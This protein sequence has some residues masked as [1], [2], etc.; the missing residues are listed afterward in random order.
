MNDEIEESKETAAAPPPETK[1]ETDDI[2]RTLWPYHPSYFGIRVIETVPDLAALEG[3]TDE[4]RSPLVELLEQGMKVLLI[5][6]TVDNHGEMLAILT[7]A[8]QASRRFGRGG[9]QA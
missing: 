7:T 2:L 9:A 5:E 8:L 6:A 1:P 4:E 3:M